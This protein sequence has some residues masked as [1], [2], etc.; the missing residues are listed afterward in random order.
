MVVALILYGAMSV[1]IIAATTNVHDVAQEEL[2]QVEFAP[3]KPEPVPEAKPA[4]PA[5]KPKPVAKKRKTIKAAP[6]VLPNQKLAESDA[7]LVNADA[8]GPIDGIIEQEKPKPPPP[9]PP[10]PPPKPKRVAKVVPPV[11]SSSNKAPK[12]TSGAKR[13]R[14][15]GVVVVQFVVEKD[16]TVGDIRIVSGPLELGKIVLKTVARWRFQPATRGGVAVAFKKTVQIQF[17][18]EKA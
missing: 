4:E 15:E 16:G 2:E 12:Y 10:P 6:K 9:K 3:A 5:P 18:L 11:A 7:P 8:V 17:R 1:S 13:A 14:I